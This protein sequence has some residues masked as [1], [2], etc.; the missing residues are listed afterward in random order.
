[1]KKSTKLPLMLD[2]SIEGI[3]SEDEELQVELLVYE[4]LGY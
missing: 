1:V 4:A 3:K 2:L